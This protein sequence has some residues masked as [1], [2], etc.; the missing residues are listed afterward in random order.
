M[1]VNIGKLSLGDP[2]DRN[3]LGQC[4]ARTFKQ[5]SESFEKAQAGTGTTDSL[6][7]VKMQL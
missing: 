7:T 4:F 1:D 5:V 6:K 3:T 2:V